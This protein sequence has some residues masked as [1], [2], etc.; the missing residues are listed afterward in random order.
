MSSRL[1]P[2]ESVRTSSDRRAISTAIR[3]AAAIISLSLDDHWRTSWCKPCAAIRIGWFASGVLLNSSSSSSVSGGG[4]R[5]GGASSRGNGGRTG[6]RSA[7]S[8][9]RDRSPDSCEAAS[10]AA[11]GSACVMAV[12]TSPT[13]ARS[14]KENMEKNYSRMSSK[15]TLAIPLTFLFASRHADAAGPS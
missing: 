1:L 4:G 2:F 10:A 3:F 5:V 7:P 11:D 12:R 9:R 15:C 13:E 6:A 8:C 14:C